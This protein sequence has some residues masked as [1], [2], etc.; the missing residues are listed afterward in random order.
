M[1]TISNVNSQD[2]KFEIKDILDSNLSGAEENTEAL[3]DQFNKLYAER[4]KEFNDRGEEVDHYIVI[5][6]VCWDIMK[7]DVWFSVS[8][9]ML[10]ELLAIFYSYF[11]SYM[12]TY[13]RSKDRKVSEGIRLIAIF[14]AA[15]LL[16][17]LFRNR[18]ILYGFESSIK[19]RRL[20]VGALY[21]KV[22]R[23][24]MK[25]MT[26]TSSGK[27]I[28]LISAD[29]FQVERGMSFFPVVIAAPFIIIA[30]YAILAL[31]VGW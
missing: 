28:S 18:Y 24:S 23:L 7:W 16:A 5:R 13:I 19:L 26:E 6:G 9:C 30:A 31:T 8:H 22:V 27:L 11:I 25:S 1:E 20:L 21:D 15:Q 17:Q 4:V 29:L 14:A 2:G 12:I 3:I 10:S